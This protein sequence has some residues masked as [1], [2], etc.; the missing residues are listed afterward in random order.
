MQNSIMTTFRLCVCVLSHVQLF[1]T[2]WTVA[3]QTSL[4]MEFPR[5]EYWSGVLFP[6]PGGLPNPGIKPMSLASPEVA[7]GFFTT[8]E[9]WEA[10]YR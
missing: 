6:T 5:Q 7:G 3:L 10:L 1:V 4:P 9:T 8:C 2:P